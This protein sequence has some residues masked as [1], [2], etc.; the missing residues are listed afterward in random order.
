MA[1]LIFGTGLSGF[2]GK[3]VSGVA[4]NLKFEKFAFPLLSKIPVLGDIFF[5]QNLL[6]YAMY[7]IVPLSMF[8]IY[9]TRFGLK[10]RA[11]GE[12]PAA[13]PRNPLRL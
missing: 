2:L 1:M 11:L 4:A 10:L 7:L 5:K 13:L 9:R 12:N 6:T 8:Y 3:D